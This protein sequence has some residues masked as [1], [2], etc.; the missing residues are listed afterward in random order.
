MK[1]STA[2]DRL[3][4]D[5]AEAFFS[6]LFNLNPKALMLECGRTHVDIDIDLRKRAALSV[7]PLLAH[8]V[9]YEHVQNRYGRAS[10]K[11]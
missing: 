7:M 10:V 1:F 2:L 6:F 5:G 11:P 3:R 8:T 9:R 4:N